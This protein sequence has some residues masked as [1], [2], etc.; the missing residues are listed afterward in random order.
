[1]HVELAFPS[2]RKNR[3]PRGIY[4][5][6][7]IQDPELADQSDRIAACKL[8]NE[9]VSLAYRVTTNGSVQ[10]VYLDSREGNELYRKTLCFLLGMAVKELFPDRKL[11]ISHS[12]SNGFYYYFDHITDAMV[13]DLQIIEKRMRELVDVDEPIHH[14]VISYCDAISYFE[15]HGQA[16]TA[17]LLHYRSQSKVPVYRC[18]RYTDLSHGPLLS[19][20]GWLKWF[21][22][23]PYAPGFLLRFP[24]DASSESIP[25][26]EHNPVL[27]SIYQEYNTWGKILNMDCVGL[28]NR[29][30]HDGTI[31]DFIQ[32]AEA[33]HDKKIASISDRICEKREKIRLVLIAGPSSSGK[34]TFTK[35]LAIQLK[36]LGRNPISVS[37]DDYFL[38][39]DVTPKDI[40]GKPDF[41][42]LGA[43]DIARLNEHLIRLFSGDQVTIPR[44]DFVSGHPKK[45]G[46]RLK[47]PE[48]SVL[49][50]E[51]I[52]GLNDELTRQIPR[53]QK[54]KIYVS[55]LTQL[56][57]D[58]HNRIRTTDNRL[59]RRIV[60]DHKFR[61]NTA[62][63]T[64]RM[65]L[66]VRRGEDE[67]IFPF[68]N[69]ADAAFNSAL[70]YELAVLKSYAEPLLRTIKP[71]VPEYTEARRL[72]LFLYNFLPIEPRLVPSQSILREFI[73]NSEFTY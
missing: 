34:T 13:A 55:A 56:N 47:L 5:S 18:G 64:L 44:Y 14:A 27:F 59:I 51:G 33:L 57:L 48:R 19:R 16:D 66:A 25:A 49:L 9:I 65:W 3:F 40:D 58:N 43:I 17:L 67:N 8:N 4:I 12:L 24:R 35:K 61:G 26:L 38:P 28:L 29:H 53:D 70:D 31:Q 72:L 15:E 7:I 10:P 11:V 23:C 2:G 63:D 30:I 60:R 54:F 32:V 21:E 45:E 50:L 71:D 20:T 73:G 52:H 22:L 39:R 62:F 36:V 37:L 42:S 69:S 1:M 46:V 6:E 68:Q 41:E